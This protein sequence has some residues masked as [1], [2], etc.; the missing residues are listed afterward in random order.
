MP[1]KKS[2]IL[3]PNYIQERQPDFDRIAVLTKRAIGA[4]SISDFSKDTKICVSTIY[5]ILGSRLSTP[6]SDEMLEAIAKNACPNSQITLSHLLD[7]NGMSEKK[8]NENYDDVTFKD[9]A[10]IARPEYEGK[11]EIAGRNLIEN[12]F[13]KLGFEYSVIDGHEFDAIPH[14]TFDV[15]YKTNALSEHSI[16]NWSFDFVYCTNKDNKKSFYN[17]LSKVFAAAF[18]FPQAMQNRAI[19][20]AT[21]ATEFYED[22]LYDF[23]SAEITTPISIIFADVIAGKI[24]EEYQIPKTEQFMNLEI[25]K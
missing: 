14:Y 23:C 8:Q 1:R 2:K 17:K 19:T 15:E 6:L 7:A 11:F 12:R 24:I 3:F 9:M 4:R 22:I 10:T 21:N 16:T 18:L 5:K 25:L 20:I 13:T